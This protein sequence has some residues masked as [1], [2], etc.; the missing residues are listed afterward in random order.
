[1]T[2]QCLVDP[3]DPRGE[4]QTCKKVSKESRKVV[5]KLP[6]LRYKMTEITVSRTDDDRGALELTK[7]WQGFDMKDIGD[8]VTPEG[9]KIELSL[10]VCSSP[11]TIKVRKFRP[12][13][14]DITYRCWRDGNVTKKTDIEP[15]A[16]ESIR[17][18]AKE[19][20]AYIHDNAVKT[21]ATLSE[22]DAMSSITRETYRM[23][24]QH[25]NVLT[26]GGPARSY[27]TA[28]TNSFCRSINSKIASRRKS[29]CF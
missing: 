13:P 3:E 2:L 17:Q 26:V 6:C 15:Y 1:M 20:T 21:L 24:I 12:I 22:D 11:I 9:R 19:V 23:A 27:F 29:G 16:L 5:H 8:W 18:S 28:R 7:R 14:G 10:G 25:Y 4:C